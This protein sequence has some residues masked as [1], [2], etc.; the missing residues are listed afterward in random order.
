MPKK[1]SS[2]KNNDAEGVP[3][4]AD[5]INTTNGT[6]VAP[7]ANGALAPEEQAS[8]AYDDIN[9]PLFVAPMQVKDMYMYMYMYM[10]MYI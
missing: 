9:N 8:P 10:F 2:S 3:D 1:K 7:P 5:S 4:W 6:D